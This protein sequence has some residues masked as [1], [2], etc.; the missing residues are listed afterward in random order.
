MGRQ[1]LQPR[2]AHLRSASSRAVL[3]LVALLVLLLGVGTV[4]SNHAHH[5]D[6][7]GLIASS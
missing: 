2:I 1:A 4:L 5:P 6:V 7:I 3:V